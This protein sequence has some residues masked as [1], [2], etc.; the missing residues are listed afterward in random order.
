MKIAHKLILGMLLPACLIAIVSWYASTVAQERLRNLINE[1]TVTYAR[2]VM[3]E[4]DRAMLFRISTWQAYSITSAVQAS[5]KQANSEMAALEN[6][7]T[8]IDQR[9][10]E[11]RQNNKQ[12]T[13]FM[14]RLMDNQISR[15][16]RSLRDRINENYGFTV[17]PEIFITNRY[18]ANIGQSNIT[19]DYRQ[20]DESWWKTARDQG[21]YVGDIEYDDSAAMHATDLAIRVDD[22]YGAF[23]GVIKVVASISDIQSIITTNH[24][25]AGTDG[26]MKTIFFTGDRKIIHTSKDNE[27]LLRSGQDYFSGVELS[28]DLDVQTIQ[29]RDPATGKELL[30]TYAV[31]LGFGNDAGLNWVLLHEYQADDIYKPVIRLKRNMLLIAAGATLI[32]LVAGGSIALSLSRRIRQLVQATERFGHGFNYKDVEIE[33]TDELSSLGTSF[34]R[35]SKTVHD[36]FEK[37]KKIEQSLRHTNERMTQDLEAA[38][39]IQMALLPNKLPDSHRACFSWAF[40]PS[41]GLAGDMLNIFSIDERH[42]GMY[43]FDVCGHGVRSSLLSIALSHSL[44]PR[45]DAES[46]VI[47]ADGSVAEPVDV[48]SQ[49]NERYQMSNYGGLYAT[50]LYGVLDLDNGLFRYVSAGHAGPILVD[51]DNNIAIHDVPAYPVGM[52]KDAEYSESSLELNLGDRMYLYTDGVYEE[53]N[54]SGKIFGRDAVLEVLQTARLTPLAS[55]IETLVNEVQAW[56]GGNQFHDDLTVIGAE[57]KGAH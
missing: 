44:T 27:V 9:D 55:S 20:D 18:G 40:K 56:C 23:L 30:S 26:S 8:I 35:M 57:Y 29:R 32:A 16:L 31:S 33:G 22:E 17:Y 43:V 39:V 34:N 2:A 28:K 52:F 46:L 6:A 45:A 14:R 36:E 47:L 11:W 42:I 50:I 4:I 3:A 21:L 24:S 37:R 48:V 54:Q 1:T 53:R 13:R 12:P 38:A 41:A 10:T 5:L 19:S 15:E 7:A 49:L 51:N 25:E